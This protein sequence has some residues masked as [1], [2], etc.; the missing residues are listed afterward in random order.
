M[1]TIGKKIKLFFTSPGYGVVGASSNR[2]KF[3][4]KVLRSYLQNQ[5]IAYPINPNEKMIEGV[6]CLTKI[7]DL[8]ANV[9]VFLS[10]HHLLSLKKSCSKQLKKG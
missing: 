7:A 2:E 8:P 5:K 6:T 4:N 3:G 10:S 1:E 9:K